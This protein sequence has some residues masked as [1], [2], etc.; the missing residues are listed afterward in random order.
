MPA[1]VSILQFLDSARDAHGA[2]S[3]QKPIT[4]ALNTG[5]SRKHTSARCRVLAD[6]GLVERVDTG[7]YRLSELGEGVVNRE[8]DLRELENGEDIEK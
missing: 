1:D 2:P 4:I 7:Q 8:V 3:I 5:Y 6:H